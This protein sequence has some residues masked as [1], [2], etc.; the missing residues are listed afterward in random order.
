M[1][2]L[3]SLL[4]QVQQLS[5]VDLQMVTE[6]GTHTEYYVNIIRMLHC[7]YTLIRRRKCEYC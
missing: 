3:D 2:A 5:L 7:M 4:L 6:K 1:N